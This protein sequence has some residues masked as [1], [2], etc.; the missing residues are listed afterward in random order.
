VVREIVKLVLAVAII[1]IMAALI[2]LFASGYISAFKPGGT[3][4]AAGEHVVGSTNTISAGGVSVVST[5]GP[6]PSPAGMPETVQW[7]Q[8]PEPTMPPLQPVQPP[9]MPGT[10]ETP[11]L[12]GMQPSMP[13]AGP[14]SRIVQDRLTPMPSMPPGMQPPVRV[15]K[16]VFAWPIALLPGHGGWMDVSNWL[17]R[18]VPV[19]FPGLYPGWTWWS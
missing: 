13:E 8:E 7:P 3:K 4:E 10:V 19:L 16:P 11:N 18:I 5:P 6:S 2:A 15:E 9:A 14:D 1:V 17:L 12:P